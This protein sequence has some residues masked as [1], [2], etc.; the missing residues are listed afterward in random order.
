MPVSPIGL[1]G[2]DSGYWILTS[3]YYLCGPGEA[4]QMVQVIGFL[5]SMW[6][7]CIE[8]LI[9]GPPGE[10]IYLVKFKRAVKN[11]ASLV[12]CKMRGLCV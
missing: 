2:L 11:A 9:L 6:D 7:I 4:M 8:F 12:L 3:A 5:V 1:S 10:Q